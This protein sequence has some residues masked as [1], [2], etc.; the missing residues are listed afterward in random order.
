MKKTLL[1]ISI[2]IFSISQLAVAQ[3][4]TSDFFL[5]NRNCSVIGTPNGD[6]KFV[7]KVEKNET[8]LAAFVIGYT[9]NQRK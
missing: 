1:I 2:I 3:E 7:L 6:A 9:V 5:G 4:N 8:A